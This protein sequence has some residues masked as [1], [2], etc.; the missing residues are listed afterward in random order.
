MA[1]NSRDVEILIDTNMVILDAIYNSTL[2][3]RNDFAKPIYELGEKDVGDEPMWT[4]SSD[5]I[6]A[7]EGQYELTRN[8]LNK[9]VSKSDSAF[10]TLSGQLVCIVETL[11]TLYLERSNWM[12]VSDKAEAKNVLDEYQGKI[13]GWLRQLVEYGQKEGAMKICQQFRVFRPLVEILITDWRLNE[14]SHNDEVRSQDYISQLKSFITDYGYEFASTLFNYLI[15]IKKLKALIVYFEEFSD[16]LDKFFASKDYGRISWAHEIRTGNFSTAGK[17]LAKL[18]LV[19]TEELVPNKKLQLSLAKLSLIADNENVTKGE[20]ISNESLVKEVMAMMDTID[21]QGLLSSQIVTQNA[22]DEELRAKGYASLADVLRRVVNKIL[23][24][25]ALTVEELVDGLTLVSATSDESRLNFARA[26]ELV[27]S[28]QRMS[29]SRRSLNERIICTRLFVVD[30]WSNILRAM[31]QKSDAKVQSIMEKTVLYH[32]IKALMED[33]RG[34]ANELS[35]YL[36]EPMLCTQDSISLVQ[37]NERYHYAN[38]SLLTNIAND[39]AKM[40][41][42]ITILIKDLELT[43]WIKGI[44]SR[45]QSSMGNSRKKSIN[46]RI[47]LPSLTRYSEPMQQDTEANAD[48]IDMSM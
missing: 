33:E 18:P 34:L 29:E 13:N 2:G 35:K 48:D 30:D 36:N 28:D 8:S 5:L 24:K 16:H 11:S 10:G 25:K 39:I 9:V 4:S 32:T 19:N 20:Q 26:L 7:I 46:N 14:E 3:V 45:V 44:S 27:Y 1:S 43:S 31:K 40:Q 15:E 21:V 12:I 38:E 6:T 47:I 41:K 37:L 17:T 22:T 42:E 23:Q